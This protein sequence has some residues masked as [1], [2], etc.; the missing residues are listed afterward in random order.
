MLTRGKGEIADDIETVPTSRCPP[1]DGSNNN[2]G[3]RANQALNLEDVE[4]SRPRGINLF[5]SLFYLCRGLASLNFIAVAILAADALVASR[6]KRIAAV[7]RGG[8]VPRQNDG[9]NV[10]GHSRVIKAT[11]EFINRMWAECIANFRTI[12]GNANDG[13]IRAF[14]GA[15]DRASGNPTMVGHIGE[16]EALNLAP[17][18]G[19]E[20]IRNKIQ[21]THTAK[22]TDLLPLGPGTF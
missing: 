1:G 2:L 22:N 12:E 9:G 3:H 21:C 18:L 15:V 7:A 19:V 20:S 10:T 11:V 16:L 14:G 4:S 17:A 6:T 5:P 8:A 13:Q